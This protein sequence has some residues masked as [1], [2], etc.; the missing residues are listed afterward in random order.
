MKFPKQQVITSLQQFRSRRDDVLHEDEDTFFHNLGRFIE[1]CDGDPLV[2]SI[3][4][5]GKS[6]FSNTTQEWWDKIRNRDRD[7]TNLWFPKD[8]RDELI[9]RY[10][11]L[12]DL[13]EHSNYIH[14]FGLFFGK[15]KRDESV[16]LFRS[17]AD[18]LTNRLSEEAEI[19]SPEMRD[20][21]A[22]PLQWIPN[23]NETR[24]FLSHKSVDKPIV[25]RYYQAL[26]ELGFNPWLDVW[27][28]PAG[29][30]LERDLL[31][32][33]QEACAA[34][35]FVTENFK[36]EN[37]LATEVDYAIQQK[38]KKREKFAIITLLYSEPDN[39]P[40][41]LRGYVYKPVKNDLEGMWEVIR[42]LPI[43]LG[44][45]R[46]KKDVVDN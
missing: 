6:D 13:Q 44:P 14:S 34:V 8:P 30:N 2:Q 4:F 11:I 24:I 41:L 36:D 18:E 27:D 33:F 9:F 12:K 7:D 45:M 17:F 46:W 5:T 3:L 15:T 26:K 29:K 28:M 35:F 10:Q 40:A 42:A 31:K 1:F 23:E 32:G 20:L 22:V 16:Q 39:V 43:E 37:Y 19:V 38:R 25:N 21:Q